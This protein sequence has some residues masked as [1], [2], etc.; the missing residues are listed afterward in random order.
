[1]RWLALILSRYTVARRH[2][3]VAALLAI[4]P[5][6][7]ERVALGLLSAMSFSRSARDTQ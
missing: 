7:S 6:E 1:M 5:Q 2:D 3:R 4:V